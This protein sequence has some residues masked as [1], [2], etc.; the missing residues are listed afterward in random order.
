MNETGV[1]GMSLDFPDVQPED[2]TVTLNYW[3]LRWESNRIDHIYLEKEME[4]RERAHG[5]FCYCL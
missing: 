4:A 1:G 3:R 2:W 5:S